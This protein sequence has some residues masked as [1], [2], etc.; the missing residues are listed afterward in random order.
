MTAEPNRQMGLLARLRL[1]GHILEVPKGPVKTRS[2]FCPQQFHDFHRFGEAGHSSFPR[3]TKD[4]LMRTQ[5]ASSQ[6]DA[7]NRPPAAHAVQGG[8]AFG[9]LNRV[10]ERQQDN[11]STE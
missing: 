11:R 7:E 8:I 9:E 6:T 2:G 10:P 3:I 5:M 1:H 4:L